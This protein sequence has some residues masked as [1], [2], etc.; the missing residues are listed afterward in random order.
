MESNSPPDSDIDG[1]WKE[2]LSEYLQAFFALCLP[3]VHADIDWTRGFEFLDKELQ[4]IVPES[5]TGKR[6]VDLLVRVWRI[7]GDEQW[8]L[9]HLEVQAQY[10]VG[11]PGRMFEYH[12]RIFDSYRQPVASFAV[13]ADDNP[14]WKPDRLT[15]NLWGC[16]LD[17]RFPIV[18]LTDLAKDSVTLEQSDNPFAVIIL[19]HLESM[20]SRGDAEQR[21]I[22][23]IRLIKS[24]YD[25]WGRDDVRRLVRLIDW[26]IRLPR[27]LE[28]KVREEV[29][30]FEQEKQ[31]PYVTSFERLAK[32]EGEAIG[33]ARGEARGE[34][35]GEAR[36]VAIG[37]AIG[38]QDAIAMALEDRFGETGSRLMEDI[39]RIQDLDLLRR[40]FG[41]IQQCSDV[42]DVHRILADLASD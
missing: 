15:Y 31:M 12:Y 22:G 16:C 37:K 9:I 13:L 41:T 6:S 36:G 11:F 23:K 18:K 7:N 3:A 5:E 10:E 19:A 38:L 28:L 25:R 20:K 24:L 1:A 40:I 33:E 42:A 26:L 2:A 17:F 29:E 14:N 21:R 34:A 39:R 8:V 4:K 30:A 27:T 35:I 32:E